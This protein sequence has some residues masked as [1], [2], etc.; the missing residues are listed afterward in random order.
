MEI[1]TSI[2]EKLKSRT[3]LYEPAIPLRGIYPKDV[4][5]VYRRDICISMVIAALFTLAKKWNWSKCLPTE[6]WKKKMW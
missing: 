4:K 3:I 6:K 5:P 1:G 2:R